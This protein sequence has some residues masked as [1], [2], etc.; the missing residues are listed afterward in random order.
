MTKF[1]KIL[2][3]LSNS[4]EI[5]LKVATKTKKSCKLVEKSQQSEMV[6]KE[7]C[8]YAAKIGIDTA[9]N[10][11]CNSWHKVANSA[12]PRRTQVIPKLPLERL[13]LENAA[14]ERAEQSSVRPG[15]RSLAH[16]LSWV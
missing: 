10:E 11:P 8:R 1:C 2:I 16:V 15:S 3:S 9:E 4:N 5:A 12:I 13:Q 14:R 7:L 6:L